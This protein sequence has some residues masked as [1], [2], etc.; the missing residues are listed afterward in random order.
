MT[1][2][3]LLLGCHSAAVDG[4]AETT[5]EGGGGGFG[6]E[7]VGGVTGADWDPAWETELLPVEI[8]LPAE[9]WAALCDQRRNI[10][11]VLAGDCQSGPLESPYTWFEADAVVGGQALERVGVRK[12]GL[13]GSESDTKPSLKLDFDHYVSGQLLDG[14]ER[15]TLNNARQDPSYLH[16]CLGYSVFAAAGVPAPRC[17]FAEVTVNGEH[18]GLY[19]NVEPIKK[20][21]LR[22]FFDDDSGNLYEGTLSDFRDGWVE[23]FQAKNDD[24]DRAELRAV[25]EALAADD[26]AAAL[27][28][29]VDMDAFLRFWAAE[30]LIGHWDGYAGNT[31]NFYVYA[32]PTTGLLYFLPWGAD[33]V[34]DREY[35]FGDGQPTATVAW[36]ALT[37]AAMADDGLR[38]RYAAELRSLL[39]EAWD[40]AALHAQVDEWSE[41]IAPALHDDEQA[42]FAATVEEIRGFIDRRRGQIEGELDAGLAWPYGLRDTPCLLE[43]GQISATFQT[44]WGSAG[45]AD[46]TSAGEVEIDLE[47]D[48]A[49]VPASEAGA[50]AGPSSDSVGVVALTATIGHDTAVMAYMEIPTEQIAVGTID[51]DWDGTATYLLYTTDLVNWSVVG[52]LYGGALTLSQAGT[53]SGDTIAGVLAAAAWA[54][55]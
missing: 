55:Q 7:T 31:N 6:V 37:A 12:K 20:P 53:S 5:S 23:T 47:W 19:A 42:D 3:L 46:W 38:E 17:G 8:D 34:M 13:V 18:L 10:V 44:T 32:D 50:V 15:L 11:E 9:D 48:G 54:G 43:R 16:A 14:A 21:L 29:L 33:A 28:P 41:R 49:D 35:P 4:V 2:L 24:A 30:V 1:P 25:V 45:W 27:E 51:L 39:E 36:G 22:R 26:P 40:E 52:Y